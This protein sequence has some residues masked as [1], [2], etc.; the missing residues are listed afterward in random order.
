[1]ISLRPNEKIYLIKRRH[2][3]VLMRELFPELLIFA[4]VIILMIIIAFSPLPSL[5][6]WLTRFFPSLLEFNL[7]Y[8]SLFFLSLFLLILWTVIFFI[9][10]N[11][12]L[13]YWIVTNE[14]TIQTELRGL[15]SRVL[16]DVNHDRIQDITVDVKGFLPTIFHFGDLHIQTAGEFREFVFRQIPD[17]YE[18]KDIIFKAQREFLE[19][20]KKNG[21]L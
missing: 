6:D 19:K 17:P 15:F 13:D 21:I 9:V 14:R 8:L 5:P 18:T 7:R 1:M 4:V 11:Y 16:S 20:M 3:I 12:Y 10:T 2:R